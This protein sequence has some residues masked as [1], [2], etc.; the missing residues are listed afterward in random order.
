MNNNELANTQV[1]VTFKDNCIHFYDL[2]DKYNDFKGF[3][4]NVR[5]IENAWFE[6]VEVFD[7]STTF[8]EVQDFLDENNLRTHSCC[9][10]D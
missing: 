5:G 2:L 8:A 3:T 1:R 7:A 9:G 6:L 10:M 4:Q